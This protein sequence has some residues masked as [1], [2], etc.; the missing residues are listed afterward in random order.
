MKPWCV[1]SLQKFPH[2]K[3]REVEDLLKPKTDRREEGEEEEEREEEDDENE[4]ERE[5]EGR[6]RQEMR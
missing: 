5:K 1:V 3:E 6:W 4:E 2:L